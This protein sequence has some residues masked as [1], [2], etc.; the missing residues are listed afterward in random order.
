[1]PHFANGYEG[2]TVSL[3]CILQA[4]SHEDVFIPGVTENPNISVSVSGE[5]AYIDIPADASIGEGTVGGKVEFSSKGVSTHQIPM[6]TALTISDVIP[7]ANFATVAADVVNSRWIQQ[8]EKLQDTMNLKALTAVKAAATKFTDATV[9][10]S[11]NIYETIVNDIKE[12]ETNTTNKAL[13]L[14]PTGIIVGATAKA[15]LLNAPQF[16]R[17]TAV[18]DAAVTGGVI[19]SIDGKPVIESVELDALGADYLI[20]NCLGIGVPSN[21]NSAKQFDATPLGYIDGT[22]LAG[23]VGYGVY[24][25]PSFVFYHKGA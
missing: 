12:F 11:A 2:D 21:V 15:L 13:K 4:Q 9:L 6:T 22:A 10:T 7:H 24:A 20:V 18:G 25:N 17:S 5:I 3:N 19:G 8:T 16:L 14:K 23:E 1:M